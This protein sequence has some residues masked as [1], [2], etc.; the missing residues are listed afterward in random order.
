MRHFSVELIDEEGELELDLAFGD[1]W[2]A[3]YGGGGSRYGMTQSSYPQ[4]TLKGVNRFST[5]TLVER[6]GAK[7]LLN[8]EGRIFLRME[9]TPETA[10]HVFLAKSFR[11]LDMPKNDLHEA[12]DGWRTKVGREV[13]DQLRDLEKKTREEASLVTPENLKRMIKGVKKRVG[14]IHVPYIK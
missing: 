5:K 2:N 1:E 14:E 8:P 6:C 7:F 10:P 12:N 3:S 13:S 9:S 4:I 11:H